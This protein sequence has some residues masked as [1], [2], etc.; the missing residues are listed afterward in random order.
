VSAEA[1]QNDELLAYEPALATIAM[2]YS[3]EEIIFVLHGND[4]SS[5]QIDKINYAAII[6]CFA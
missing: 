1:I 4:F 3:S 5:R 6:F 2:N